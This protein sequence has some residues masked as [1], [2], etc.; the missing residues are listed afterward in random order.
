MMATVL[1][2][3][4]LGLACWFFAYVFRYGVRTGLIAR[5]SSETAG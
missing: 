1:A 4:E 5:Y 2:F 3:A